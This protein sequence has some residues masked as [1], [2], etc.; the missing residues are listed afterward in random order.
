MSVL[1]FDFV[2]GHCLIMQC[3]VSVLVLGFGF[4][5]CLVMPCSVSVL[6]LCLVI[7]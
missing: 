6:V 5:H 1:V 2:F 4:G 7:V 3:S